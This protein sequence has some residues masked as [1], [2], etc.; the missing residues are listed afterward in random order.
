MTKQTSGEK[1]TAKFEALWEAEMRLRRETTGQALGI[2]PDVRER[3][4]RNAVKARKALYVLI[5]ELTPE[6]GVAYG[7]YRRRILTK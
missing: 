6:E 7:A 1:L 4:R 5:D 3:G 2:T